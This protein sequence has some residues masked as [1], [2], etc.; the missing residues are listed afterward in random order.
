VDYTLRR[1]FPE[2]AEEPEPAIA[3]LRE[4]VRRQA[5]LIAAWM[6]VGFVH[7]VMNTDNLALSGETI[8]Y[9]PCAFIDEHDPA[10]VFSSIDQHGRYAFGNQPAIARWNL[11]RFAESLLAV[12]DPDPAIAVDK[13][14]QQLSRFAGL[15]E[16]EQLRRFR[17]KIGLPGIEA[18]DTEIIRELLL[19]LARMRADHTHFFRSLGE[20]RALVE[21]V[22]GGV[23]FAAWHRR[24]LERLGAWR[25]EL[26]AARRRMPQVNPRVVPRNWRVQAA[27]DAAVAGDPAPFRRLVEI[28]RRPFD[29]EQIL[30]PEEAGPALPGREPYVTYCGT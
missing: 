20:P 13:A 4:V 18:M 16:A 25:P 15:Q 21:P 24:W 22:L 28:L 26:E 6:S 10:A 27:L 17:E 14:N 5:S 8:D 23:E 7:G 30:T 9:G 11:A 3:L 12:I 1:H 19:I 29:P 2:A